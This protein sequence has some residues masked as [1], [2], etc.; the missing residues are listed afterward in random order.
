MI[1]G[2]RAE[3]G[4]LGEGGGGLGWTGWVRRRRRGPGGG[5]VALAARSI[6]GGKEQSMIMR[7]LYQS[8]G[9]LP[10]PSPS[11]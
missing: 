1:G 7:E 11:H 9:L 10:E 5:E 8:A 2:G 6:K 4:G 3:L